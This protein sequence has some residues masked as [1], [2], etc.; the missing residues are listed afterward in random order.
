MSSVQGSSLN[1][2]RSHPKRNSCSYSLSYL[3]GS[4][5][6]SFAF[7]SKPFSSLIVMVTSLFRRVLYGKY[8]FFYLFPTLDKISTHPSHTAFVEIEK[9]FFRSKKI[10]FDP[11]MNETAIQLQSPISDMTVRLHMIR[12]DDNKADLNISYL[13]DDTGK[14]EEQKTFFGL[15]I[16][17][18][19]Y[20]L[21]TFF[22][23]DE[24]SLSSSQRKWISI[25]EKGVEKR[26]YFTFPENRSYLEVKLPLKGTRWNSLF[27]FTRSEAAPYSIKVKIAVRDPSH[28][29]LFEKEYEG[30][31]W[32]RSYSLEEIIPS[33]Y[34]HK[35]EEKH[36]YYVDFTEG[37]SSRRIYFENLD[38]DDFGL[39]TKNHHI[40]FIFQR[41][42]TQQNHVN[43]EVALYHKENLQKR[44]TT[45]NY[46][47][48]PFFP[49]EKGK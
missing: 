46:P 28:T 41:A 18:T 47:L 30:N 32:P 8:S 40:R 17:Y 25:K 15:P 36:N 13:S 23:H 43:V 37:N 5:R 3:S 34:L 26:I 14:T 42:S 22:P 2:E 35:Q 9:G 49:I 31:Y 27:T 21:E 20:S 38:K 45:K 4:L 19:S 10:F 16:S 44:L 6:R 29:L 48:L 33:N 12:Q 11:T 7:F 1:I 39:E 24:I